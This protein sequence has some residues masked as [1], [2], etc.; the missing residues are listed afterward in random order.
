LVFND[1]NK[2]KLEMFQR[3]LKNKSQIQKTPFQKYSSA[4]ELPQVKKLANPKGGSRGPRYHNPSEAYDNI[5][6]T[7][8]VDS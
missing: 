3:L 8:K 7:G 1:Q 6:V 4:R 5:F 2:T